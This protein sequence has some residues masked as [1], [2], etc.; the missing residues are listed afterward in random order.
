MESKS[1]LKRILDKF[2][3]TALFSIFLDPEAGQVIPEEDK[4]PEERIKSLADSTGTSRDEI[5]DIEKAFNAAAKSL[6][7]ITAE[8]TRIPD[9]K[10]NSKNPFKV[11]ESELVL[12]EA[13][14][15]PSRKASGREIGD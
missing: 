7:G 15:A 9:E 12:D 5:A 11:D 8:T 3:K 4:N 6:R 13:E 1:L 2:K 10:R 14:Q